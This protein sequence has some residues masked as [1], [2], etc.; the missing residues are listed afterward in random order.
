[1]S[2]DEQIYEQR[3]YFPVVERRQQA[4]AASIATTRR[5]GRATDDVALP[6]DD[7]PVYDMRSP[8]SVRRYHAPPRTEIRVTRHQ[9]VPPRASK[10]QQQRA[11]QSQ[12]RPRRLRRS[13]WFYVGVGMCAMLLLYYAIEEASALEQR[14]SENAQYGYPRTFQ[15][16]AN[17][18]H[19][20]GM[21]HF[22]V[23]NLH[24]HVFM[25]E[26]PMNNLNA[27]KLYPG[28][29]LT[30]AD[31]DLAPATVRFRDVNGDGLPDML[32]T[33]GTTQVTIY[34]NTGQGF[35]LANANDHITLGGV[36]L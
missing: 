13:P 21:S 22:V 34:I 8:T 1:M 5:Q 28:P 33:V 12:T 2:R 30:G 18:K 3:A 27:S 31:A 35:R 15:C 4:Q 23:E 16:D 6:D 36:Y 29:V 26:M 7:A 10:E 20:G 14:L 9:G 24:G 25:L 19:D 11:P 17:V 32:L